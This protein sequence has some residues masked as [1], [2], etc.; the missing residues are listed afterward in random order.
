MTFDAVAHRLIAAR[1]GGPAVPF[2]DVL[3]ADRAGAYAIQDATV[4]G[5]GP[6]G[7][8]KV[9]GPSVEAEPTAAPLP[10]AGLRSSGA[11][12]EG[13]MRGAELEVALRIGRDIRPNGALLSAAALAACIGAVLPA[14]EVVETRLADWKDAD[15]LAQLADLGT[16]AALVLGEPASMDPASL[17]LRTV[18]ARLSFGGRVVA[19]TRGGNTASDVWRSLAWLARHAEA[20]GRPLSVGDVVTTGSCTGLLFAKA[21]DR[22]EGEIAGLGRVAV[23]F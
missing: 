23:Q 22:V 18:E 13:P 5:L 4:A 8:W 14:I 6:V 2:R 12:F 20:R 17:D 9:G 11:T 19:E 16:H 21:G 15:P 1:R 7:G 3:P 10:E